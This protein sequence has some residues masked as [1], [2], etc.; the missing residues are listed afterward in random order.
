MEEYLAHSAQNGVP[1]QSYK[2]HVRGVRERGVRYA[3]EAGKYCFM[4]DACLSDAV[5]ISAFYHDLGKLEDENQKV[6]HTNSSIKLPINHVDAGS[7]VLLSRGNTFSALAVYAHHRGLPDVLTEKNRGKHIFR[8]ADNSTREK[9]DKRLPVLLERQKRCLW[10]ED[11]LGKTI[12]QGNRSVF[13]RM[14]LSCLADADHSDAAAAFCRG[15]PE[16][17]VSLLPEQRL[18]ALDEYVA[19]LPKDG[20]RNQLRWEMYTACR[21]SKVSGGF[22]VC[23][24]PV[25]S[26]K[27]TAIIAHLLKQSTLRGARRI[28]VVLPYTSIIQQSVEV[29]RKALVLPGEDPEM[30]VAEHHFRADYESVDSR[31]LTALWR[32][33]IVVTTSVAFFETLASNGPS[34]LRRFHELPGSMIFVDEAHNALPLKLLPLAWQWMNILANEWGCYWVLASG[35]LVDLCLF[36]PAPARNLGCDPQVTTHI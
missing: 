27:T 3:Q 30:V 35:S 20:E 12:Y 16:S 10:N 31:H 29:Y 24:S 25:G 7:A 8:D 4:G 34:G 22:T 33:P 36:V 11:L 23:D 26:G 5:R 15:L 19:K 1:A 21:D 9:V 18:Q 32:A 14:L 6:L 28:F 2:D 13:S 17:L